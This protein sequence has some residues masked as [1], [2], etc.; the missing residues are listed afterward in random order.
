MD[1]L[2]KS[3]NVQISRVILAKTSDAEDAVVIYVG[4][5]PSIG[6]RPES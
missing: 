1:T 2:I 3:I 6:Y 5:A 4:D